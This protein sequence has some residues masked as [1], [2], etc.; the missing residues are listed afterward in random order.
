MAA[1][2]VKD[3]DTEKVKSYVSDLRQL[4]EETEAVERKSFLRS[5]VK[6][7]VVDEMQVTI[8][9]TLPIPQDNSD[10]G[11]KEVLPIVTSGG[12][13]GI[14]TPDLLRAREALSQLSYSPIH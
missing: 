14:R 4:L 7:I 3:L 2:G 1:Q 8:Y 6:K 11:E 9:Y 13:E 12:A 10:R 5:F